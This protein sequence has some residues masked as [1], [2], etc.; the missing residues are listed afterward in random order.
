VFV[1]AGSQ[2]TCRLIEPSRCLIF[3]TP[4]LDRLIAKLR[5]LSEQSGLRATLAEFDTVLVE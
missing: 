1:P 3:L 2:H 4:R 5:S